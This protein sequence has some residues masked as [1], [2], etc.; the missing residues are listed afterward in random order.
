MR[1]SRIRTTLG[2]ILSIGLACLIWEAL[3]RSGLFAPA[4]APS[5]VAI[6]RALVGMLLSG[7]MLGHTAYT[8]YRVLSGL[9]LA[10]LVGVP[11]GILMGRFRACRALPR[12][13]GERP[14]ADSIVGVG[15][16][17]H[18]LVWSG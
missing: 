8:L 12:S 13:A 17:F 18:S 4:L 14:H 11:I 5:V 3:A 6:G 2:T 9:L 7:A 1:N 16:G 10:C 15:A